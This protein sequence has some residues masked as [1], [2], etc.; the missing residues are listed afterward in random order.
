[1]I[2]HQNQEFQLLKTYNTILAPYVLDKSNSNGISLLQACINCISYEKYTLQNITFL[3]NTISCYA[4][5]DACDKQGYI[6][7]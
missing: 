6:I 3:I 7:L 2:S 1:M 5:L 4:V